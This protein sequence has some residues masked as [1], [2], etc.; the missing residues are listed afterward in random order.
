M[1]LA[2][3]KEFLLLT[4]R[5]GKLATVREDG[6]PHVVPIWFDLDGEDLVF[7]TW[8]TTVKATNIRRDSRVSVC[9]D[10]QKPPFAFVMIEGEAELDE[11]PGDLEY[12]AARIA[13]RYMGPEL[14]ESYGKRNAVEGELLVRVKPTNI[15]A[16]KNIAD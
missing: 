2:E 4:P 10:D 13:G 6:R 3:I 1:N 8:H 11:H 16:R 14:A 15:I 12:W 7:T 9:V 5:T